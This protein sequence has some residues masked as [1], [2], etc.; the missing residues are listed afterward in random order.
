MTTI[1]YMKNLKAHE[2]PL[3]AMEAMRYPWTWVYYGNL[4][5]RYIP[6]KGTVESKPCGRAYD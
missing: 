1:L 2:L 6:E 4:M 3:Y 5:V